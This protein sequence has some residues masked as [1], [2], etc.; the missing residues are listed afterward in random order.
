M[1]CGKR[2]SQEVK[3]NGGELFDERLTL[4]HMGYKVL[5][6]DYRSIYQS[7]NQGKSIF[8]RKIMILRNITWIHSLI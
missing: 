8:E 5:L 4:L 1:F 3:Q 7:I 6:H 2:N